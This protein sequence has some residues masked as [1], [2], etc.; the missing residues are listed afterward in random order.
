MSTNNILLLGINP[1]SIKANYFIE[2]CQPKNDLTNSHIH[3]ECEIYL[4]LSGEVGFIAENNF[5]EIKSGDIFITKPHEYH[6]CIIKRKCLHEHFWITFKAEGNDWLLAP[7]FERN[8]GESN[9]IELDNNLKKEAINLCFKLTE[10]DN[11]LEQYITFLSLLKLIN[12][13]KV[14]NTSPHIPDDIAL[15][16]E[17][18][19]KNFRKNITVKE[20][21]KLNFVSVN[22]LER[23]FKNHV[24]ITPTA[25]IQNRRL[26]NAIAILRNGGSVTQ[27]A[28]ESGFPDYSHFISLFKKRFGKTPLQFKKEKL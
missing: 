17:Y 28:Y 27:A 8:S 18:I 24:G 3:D 16:I 19:N 5:Y 9:L 26:I 2:N 11:E 14:K 23:R 13:N 25:Y 21:C 4:N 15:Y 22:T 20:L 12:D 1:I 6:H 10:S 7:F